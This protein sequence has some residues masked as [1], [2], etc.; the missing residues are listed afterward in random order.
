[1]N[2]W[3]LGVNRQNALRTVKTDASKLHSNS[4]FIQRWIHEH[5]STLPPGLQAVSGLRSTSS[6]TTVTSEV[7]RTPKNSRIP[8]FS[9]LSHRRPPTR[10]PGGTPEKRKS[11]QVGPAPTKSACK[12]VDSSNLLMNLEGR[13]GCDS[14]QPGS[15]HQKEGRKSTKSN[16]KDRSRDFP[17]A[18]RTV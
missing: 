3:Y 2:R 12:N 6:T 8:A 5:Q 14:T 10:S 1:M 16:K 4:R 15:S 11:T 17:F 13:R 7:H 18:I 9:L